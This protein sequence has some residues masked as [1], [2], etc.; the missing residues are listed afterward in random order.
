MLEYLSMAVPLLF[1]FPLHKQ[2]IFCHKMEWVEEGEI[3]LNITVLAGLLFFFFHFDGTDLMKNT[4]LIFHFVVYTNRYLYKY[5]IWLTFKIT[6]T[7]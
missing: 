2:L 5:L 6:T 3:L 7:F 1:N 4:L